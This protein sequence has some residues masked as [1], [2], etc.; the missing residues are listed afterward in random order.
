MLLFD[1]IERKI[2]PDNVVQLLKNGIG[3]S[4]ENGW[5]I[6]VTTIKNKINIAN[7]KLE[8]IFNIFGEFLLNI[9][10]VNIINGPK[11]SKTIIQPITK[12]K[13]SIE[14]LNFNLLFRMFTFSLKFCI[15][16]IPEYINITKN[17]IVKKITIPRGVILKR[18]ISN[19]YFIKYKNK[20]NFITF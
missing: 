11:I 2:K 13:N 9:I 16:S 5:Y 10:F 3:F 15:L 8:N 1:I 18:F 14:R 12:F 7:V 4:N 20:S 19:I 6:Q 17:N